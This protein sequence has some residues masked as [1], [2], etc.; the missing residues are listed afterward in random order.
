M[1]AHRWHQGRLLTETRWRITVEYDGTR[2]CGWQIQPGQRSV[3]GTIEEAVQALFGHHT[4]VA[5]SGRTDAGVHALAQVAAFTTPVVRTARSVCGGLNDHLPD[6]IGCVDATEAP[7]E[8]DPRRWVIRKRYRYTWLDRPSRSPLRRSQSWHVRRPL[9]EEVMHMASQRMLGQH[10]FTAFRAAR[11]QASHPVRTL[12]EIAVHRE[13]ELVHL[14]IVGN[15]FLRHM[16][17]IVAGTLTEVGHGRQ[18]PEWIDGVIASRDRAA[19]GRTAPPQGLC[20]VSV[21]Y[22]DGPQVGRYADPA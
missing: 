17:R 11:C 9:D 21:T 6:D 3:Q 2:F 22:G 7:L 5:A 12:E 1:V 16:V 14:D 19:G 15:G 20:L 13:G 4:H 8:F 10:D 18:P